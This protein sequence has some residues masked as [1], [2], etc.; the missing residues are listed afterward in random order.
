MAAITGHPN[1][2]ANPGITQQCIATGL[3]AE[4]AKGFLDAAPAAAT[5]TAS[6]QAGNQFAAAMAAMGNP[7]VSGV[8]AAAPD[9][10]AA[11]AQAAA[12]WGKA[13]GIA[14]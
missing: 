10:A 12:G 9:S 5:T 13:F 11:T 8:E 7:N 4:Q 14:Q 3:S 1:A 6:A 2:A